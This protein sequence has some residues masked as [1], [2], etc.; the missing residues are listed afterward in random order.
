MTCF[1]ANYNA[2]QVNSKKGTVSWVERHSCKF[3]CNP[4][5]F[6][7]KIRYLH[8]AESEVE[9]RKE[10][11]PALRDGLFMGYRFHTGGKWT[12]QYQVI[13]SEA[14]SQV[15]KNIGRCA[16]V[17]A[18]GE[19]YVPGSAGDNHESHPTFPVADGLLQEAPAARTNPVKNSC[20]TLRTCKH[21]L[22]QL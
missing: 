17:H 3:D 4:V 12:G 20:Q 19:I 21:K 7:C 2:T 5:P 18:V 11:D 13:D 10:I 6:G 1:C 15:H 8:S 14:F 22:K 9:K 16:Y